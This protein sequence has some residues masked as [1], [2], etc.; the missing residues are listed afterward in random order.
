MKQV[1]AL[2]QELDGV[3]F[4]Y[5]LNAT[6]RVQIQFTVLKLLIPGGAVI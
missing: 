2:R 6:D 1:D 4:E 5:L 3:A